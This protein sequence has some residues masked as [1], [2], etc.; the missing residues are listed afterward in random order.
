MALV[1]K[2]LCHHSGWHRGNQGVVM[3]SVL[4][5]SSVVKIIG[6]LVI[7]SLGVSSMLSTAFGQQIG[8]QPNPAVTETPAQLQQLVAPIALYPD[9][10]VAQILAASTYPTQIVD[11][12]RWL[13]THSELQGEQLAAQ[14]DQQSWDSS[15]KA[16]T[17]FPSVVSNMDMNLQWTTSLGQAY[18]NQQQDVLDAVQVM[19]QRAEALGLRPI[20]LGERL[21]DGGG[22]LLR[23]PIACDQAKGP[24]IRSDM[25]RGHDQQVVLVAKPEQ[26]TA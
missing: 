17:A 20:A 23:L 25:V 5:K 24:V 8:A 7:L 12:D 10:L 1:L 18:F 21:R 16:L 26:D 15:V 11:A 13:G 9:E 4:S 22:R 2:T 3:K 6:R 19:R 14:V